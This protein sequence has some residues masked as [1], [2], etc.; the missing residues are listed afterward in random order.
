MRLAKFWRR[1]RLIRAG[2]VDPGQRQLHTD[3]SKMA[4]NVCVCHFLISVY[5]VGTCSSFKQKII[6]E[7][8][9]Q[10]MEEGGAKPLRR[11]RTRSSDSRWKGKI[12]Q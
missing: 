11:W 7:K 10:Q 9:R 6:A 5:S 2:K 1:R 4:L 8:C 3:D 12:K